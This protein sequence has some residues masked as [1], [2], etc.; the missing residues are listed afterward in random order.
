MNNIHVFHTVV[1]V[2]K[3]MNEDVEKY[4]EASAS[5]GLRVE[6]CIETSGSGMEC[7]HESANLSKIL[8]KSIENNEKLDAEGIKTASE[9]TAKPMECKEEA[10]GLLVIT[11]DDEA[12]GYL[13]KLG[14]AVAGY[15]AP[16]HEYESFSAK[17]VVEELP[18]VDDDY[19]N[20]IYMRAHHI[21]V[22]IARTSRTIIREM[23]EKAVPLSL[24][25]FILNHGALKRLLKKKRRK[26]LFLFPMRAWT[27]LLHGF[28]IDLRLKNPNGLTRLKIPCIL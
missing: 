14:V 2:L 26:N 10:L 4:I 16:G 25:I 15:R 27:M 17:Y 11:D 19:F 8:N 6:V 9:D 22:E 7:L 24:Y 3:Q 18:M 13:E 12:A 1:L 21:P 28:G 23:T 5:E 20:L